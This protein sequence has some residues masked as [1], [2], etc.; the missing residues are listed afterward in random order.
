MIF[1]WP[2]PNGD[3][4]SIAVRHVVVNPMIQY[5]KV[6]DFARLTLPGAI[7]ENILAI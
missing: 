2:S 6:S 5:E 4:N 7:G 3:I 1:L